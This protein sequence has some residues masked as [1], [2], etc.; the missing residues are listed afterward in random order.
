MWLGWLLGEGAGEL[1]AHGYEVL[2]VGS[3][4]ADFTRPAQ[5]RTKQKTFNLGCHFL[6]HYFETGD[7]IAS[8]PVLITGVDHFLFVSA[9]RTSHA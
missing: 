8:E 2:G 6:F 1:P 5:V 4:E 9:I 3:L 7:S